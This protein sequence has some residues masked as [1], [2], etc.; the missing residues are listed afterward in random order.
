MPRARNSAVH[1]RRQSPMV[2]RPRTAG[3]T[4]GRIGK[5]G[6]KRWSRVLRGKL[7][8]LVFG[9]Q[10]IDDFGERFALENLRQLVKRQIDA[11][12]R[13][14]ALR[15]I[16]GADAFGAVAGPDLAAPLGGPRRVLLLP[17]EVVEPGPQ[18]GER[19]GAVAVL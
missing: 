11:V 6:L 4:A 8:G 9:D 14:P 19:L 7:G 16:V 18:H 5:R 10:R 17:L 13:N 15:I 12:V 2:M 3:V 1:A